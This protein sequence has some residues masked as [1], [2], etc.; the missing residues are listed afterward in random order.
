MKDS[1]NIKQIIKST[2]EF[3]I[4][5]LTKDLRNLHKSINLNYIYDEVKN[6]LLNPSNVAKAKDIAIF[7]ALKLALLKLEKEPQKL[8]DIR[9]DISQ[10]RIMQP[11]GWETRTLKYGD[12]K[13]GNDYVLIEIKGDD[14]IE[15][16]KDKRLFQQIDE[17]VKIGQLAF[18]VVYRPMTDILQEANKRKIP[19]NVIYG[20][21]ASLCMRGCVP[22]FCPNRFIAGIV[23]NMIA[24]KVLD[25]KGRDV[26]Q[27]IREGGRREFTKDRVMFVLTSYEDVGEIEAQK[28]LKAYGNLE[29]IYRICLDKSEE[30]IKKMPHANKLLGIRTTLKG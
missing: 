26:Y 15:S 24:E 9:E 30:E 8:L 7:Y 1:R 19:D 3:G 2:E 21:T 16:I 23:I 25:G 29:N 20:T 13:V 18:L 27:H 10:K 28:L 11:M 14:F 22:L 6:D 12:C 4:G 17:I 5:R